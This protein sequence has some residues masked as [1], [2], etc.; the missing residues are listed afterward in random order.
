[1]KRWDGKRCRLRKSGENIAVG[2]NFI[3]ACQVIFSEI[4]LFFEE[5]FVIIVVVDIVYK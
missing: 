5:L 2:C 4:I 1:M 3:V